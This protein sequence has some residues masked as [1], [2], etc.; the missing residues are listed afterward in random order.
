MTNRKKEVAKFACGF[1]T[2]HAASYAVLW[3]TGTTLTVFGVTAGPTW[4]AISFGIN[5]LSAAALGIYAWRAPRPGGRV[6]VR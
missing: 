3:W 6:D 1:E 2:A 5:G 4:H